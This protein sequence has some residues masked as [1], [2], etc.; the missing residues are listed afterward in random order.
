MADFGCPVFGQLHTNSWA[1]LEAVVA[2]MSLSWAPA[3]ISTGSAR[4]QE[5][6]DALVVHVQP[7]LDANTH[8]LPYA[9][10]RGP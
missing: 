3:Q 4:V 2:A 10:T 5:G 1:E 8:S 9:S 7:D 6:F